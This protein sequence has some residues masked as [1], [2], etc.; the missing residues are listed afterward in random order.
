M[1]E[2]RIPR[3]M[4]YERKIHI[5]IDISNI[6]CGAI[7]ETNFAKTRLNIPGLIDIVRKRRE[8]VRKVSDKAIQYKAKLFMSN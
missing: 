2:S 7:A 4:D 3:E 6:L 8:V 5:Y 1:T